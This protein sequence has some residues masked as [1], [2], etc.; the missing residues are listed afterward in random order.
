MQ[1][2]AHPLFPPPLI[3]FS[4]LKILL[5]KLLKSKKFKMGQ[6]SPDR[7]LKLFLNEEE[8]EVLHD[9]EEEL[10]DD[11]YR[12]KR[13][14][15]GKGFEE[16]MRSAAERIPKME[17]HLEEVELR[18]T[19]LR[20]TIWDISAR[21]MRMEEAGIKFFE[22]LEI[23]SR[24]PSADHPDGPSG[25]MDHGDIPPWNIESEERLHH[26]NSRY[27][28]KNTRRPSFIPTDEISAGIVI[29]EKSLEIL[30]HYV[31]INYVI[32]LNQLPQL[33]LKR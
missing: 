27:Q 31:M 12:L 25:S 26:E 2:E 7:G 16:Q 3:I 30:M 15:D 6:F 32:I 19:H 14:E 33:S 28:N 24:K 5:D 8:E 13:S 18:N 9:W 23:R 20:N 22:H 17:R 29:T 10:V 11:Y 4:H 1:Y 21:I